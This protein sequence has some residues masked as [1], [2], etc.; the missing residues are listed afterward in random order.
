MSVAS[1]TPD[2]FDD[3]FVVSD[4]EVAY[5]SDTYR[6]STSSE[7]SNVSQR[8]ERSP[9]PP[10][11][12]LR[13]NLPLCYCKMDEYVEGVMRCL[14]RFQRTLRNAPPELTCGKQSRKEGPPVPH[15]QHS[16]DLPRE[17]QD[18]GE[19]H[20]EDAL[21]SCDGSNRGRGRKRIRLYLKT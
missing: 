10:G 16:L 13:S 4:S 6:S 20:M 3:D 15:L 17:L 1:E 21:D 8:D 9:P 5:D 18:G 19:P 2:G 14:E 11:A 7:T 12:A